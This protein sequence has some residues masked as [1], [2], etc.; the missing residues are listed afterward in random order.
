MDLHP[1]R[2]YPED[3]NGIKIAYDTI[4]R[5]VI[6]TGFLLISTVGNATSTMLQDC[7]FRD[8]EHVVIFMDEVGL[9]TDAG[10]VQHPGGSDGGKTRRD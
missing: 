7:T 1:L 3:N 6:V 4:R 5:Y 10:V 9:E 2:V 8:A